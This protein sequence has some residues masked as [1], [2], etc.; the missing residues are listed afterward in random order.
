ML[1]QHL[2]YLVTLAEERHFARAARACHVSQPTL[3]EGIKH[4]E[5]FLG[6]P[7]AERN[8]RFQGLTPAGERVLRWGRRIL[9]DFASLEQEIAEVREGLV[10]KLTLGAI[11]ASHAILPLLTTP[12]VDAYPKVTVSVLSQTSIEIQRAL[13]E[14]SVDVGV[15]YLDNEPLSRVDTYPLYR[16]RYVLV[17]PADGPLRGSVQATWAQAAALRLCL[18][19]E[20]M[21]NRR[22]LN[23][24]FQRA[25]VQPAPP[26]ETLSLLT[27]CAHVSFGGWSTILPH[28]FRPLL[29]GMANIQ[30]LPLVEPSV[31]HTVGLAVAQREPLP[32][33]ARTLLDL[34]RR[35]DVDAVLARA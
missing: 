31:E 14:F 20:A 4:L 6:V 22:I 28:T 17:T 15:T 12:L 23:T 30:V 10:G 33:L 5:E 3:S 24:I 29:R 1:L 35:L 9:A 34:A 21:Q 18:L 32:P 11:P 7:I 25:Q 2:R 8:Q 27:A 16:E 19:S 13:D 26:V